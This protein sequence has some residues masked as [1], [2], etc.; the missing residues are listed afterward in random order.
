M[1][2]SQEF[3]FHKNLENLS[4]INQKNSQ[5]RKWQRP[6]L[7]EFV[8]TLLPYHFLE[9]I[10]TNKGYMGKKFLRNYQEN[11]NFERERDKTRELRRKVIL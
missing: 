7:E 2:S 1:G 6:E 9:R 5:K 11:S 3:N 10:D 8:A 4:E